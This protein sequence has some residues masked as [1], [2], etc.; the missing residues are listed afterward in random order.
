MA[1]YASLQTTASNPAVY[2][3]GVPVQALVP[4]YTTSAICADPNAINTPLGIEIGSPVYAGSNL[5]PNFDTVQ[6]DGSTFLGI[7]LRSNTQGSIDFYTSGYSQIIPAGANVEILQRGS[8]PVVL[9]QSTA[10]TIGQTVYVKSPAG[11]GGGDFQTGATQP[12]GYIATNFRVSA[13]ASGTFT[14]NVTLVVIT[15]TQNVGA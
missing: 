4:S 2:Q 8:V 1:N 15:N 11:S 5:A 6:P 13:I 3:L 10:P 7:A 12:T 9:N 14:Q